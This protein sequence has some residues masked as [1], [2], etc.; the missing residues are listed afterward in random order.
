LGFPA[1]REAAEAEAK[2]E[3]EAKARREA[4]KAEAKKE[5]EAKARAEEIAEAK[6]EARDNVI[7]N[8][9]A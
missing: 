4:A 5:A 7:E 8:A 2:K 6:K 1:R 3:A 9:L